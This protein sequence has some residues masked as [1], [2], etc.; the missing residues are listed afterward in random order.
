VY[1][2]CL[3][4]IKVQYVLRDTSSLITQLSKS[5]HMLVRSLIYTMLFITD[6]TIVQ[7]DPRYFSPCP[8]TFWPER[9]LPEGPELAMA[10]NEV[11]VHDTTAFMP[12]SFGECSCPWSASNDFEL[13]GV[14]SNQLRW[15]CISLA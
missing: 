7:R 9:W 5:P 15:S 1:L 2:V 13:S 14:R 8:E 11:F 10:R 6:N 12:F 4:L 3:R